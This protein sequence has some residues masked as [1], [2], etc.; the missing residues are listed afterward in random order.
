MKTRKNEFFA[1]SYYKF[2]K[3]CYNTV[4]VDNECQ[5]GGDKGY[6]SVYEKF[7]SIEDFREKVKNE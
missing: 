4:H 3:N 1:I 7:D 2:C 5:C 6:K